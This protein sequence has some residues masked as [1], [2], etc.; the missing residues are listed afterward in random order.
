MHAGAARWYAQ[1]G[2]SRPPASALL[3]RAVR[4][5]GGGAD[6]GSAKAGGLGKGD[7]EQAR[8]GAS[9][10]GAELHRSRARP[11][12]PSSRHDGR[13][14]SAGIR[15]TTLSNSTGTK[16]ASSTASKRLVL[17]RVR[18]RMSRAHS[19]VTFPSMDSYAYSER[20]DLGF[21]LFLDRR[22]KIV[23]FI[24]NAEGQHNLVEAHQLLVENGG[25]AFYDARL[26]DKGLEECERLK[27]EICNT[28]I[29]LNFQLIITSPLT[30]ALQ[31]STAALADAGTP[32]PLLRSRAQSRCVSPQPEPLTVPV[33]FGLAGG[34]CA[35]TYCAYFVY[36][37]YRRCATATRPRSSLACQASGARCQVPGV[38]CQVKACP[39]D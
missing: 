16:N 18:S 38:R 14:K 17:G 28:K 31:T 19:E 1:S 6:E 23:H 13:S 36:I 12:A 35:T 22:C 25:D 29:P 37:V 32:Q 33:L 4:G 9:E 2:L 10:K 20:T 26:T 30:R 7:G 5:G 15:N 11:R 24:G 3:F 8:A 27:M 39:A 21:S 34:A